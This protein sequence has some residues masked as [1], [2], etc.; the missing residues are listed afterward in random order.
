MDEITVGKTLDKLRPDKAAGPDD[1]SPRL[2]AELKEELCHPVTKIMKASFDTGV[3]PDD[4]KT[5][6]VCPIFKKGSKSQIGNYRPVS[7]TSQI[8]KLYETV[9]RDAI[10]LH[11]ESNG[12]LS[13]SNMVSEKVDHA[14]VTFWNFWTMLLKIWTTITVSMSYIWTLPR[15]STRSPIADY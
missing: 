14:S 2:L 4:W 12:L 11:L 1:L 6:N 5:A 9:I 8:C 15:P 3:V 10:V 7:L 13:H